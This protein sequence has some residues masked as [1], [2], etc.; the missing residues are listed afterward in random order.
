MTIFGLWNN[1]KMFRQDKTPMWT[2]QFVAGT[3]VGG[4]YVPINR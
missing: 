3:D 4:P 1:V 2:V